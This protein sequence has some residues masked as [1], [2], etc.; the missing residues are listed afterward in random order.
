MSQTTTISLEQA[1][2]DGV[3]EV[4]RDR[5]LQLHAQQMATGK[6]RPINF[7][8]DVAEKHNY[9]KLKPLSNAQVAGTVVYIQAESQKSG[10]TGHYQILANQWGLMEALAKLD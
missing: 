8:G 4:T 10:T 7:R 5:T 2:R 1:V 9:D 3:S 6:P